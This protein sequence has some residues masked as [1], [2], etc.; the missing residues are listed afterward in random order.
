MNGRLP[1]GPELP[2]LAEKLVRVSHLP[3]VPGCFF[4]GFIALGLLNLV[5][6][7]PSYSS[8]GETAAQTLA[9]QNVGVYVVATYLFYAPRY[10]RLKILEAE[11]KLSALLE[12]GER[13]FHNLF[14]RI[15]AARPQLLAWL[16]FTIGLPLSLTVL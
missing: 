12:D 14:G 15:S 16:A 1:V 8:F 11:P 5:T 10:M 6:Y 13:G 4:Y 2:T 3:Y 7:L 9:P